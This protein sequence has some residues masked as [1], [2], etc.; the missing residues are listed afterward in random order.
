[1]TIVVERYRAESSASELTTGVHRNFGARLARCR[2][3][4]LD[5]SVRQGF[6]NLGEFWM[7]QS[8]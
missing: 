5:T 1:M 3:R 2:D 8:G 6:E 4:D 7:T